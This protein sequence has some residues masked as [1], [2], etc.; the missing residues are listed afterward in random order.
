MII[1]YKCFNKGLI[2]RYG[3]KFIIGQIYHVDKNVSFGNNKHGFHMCVNLEDTL[4]YFDS[5][6]IEIAE[7][8]GFGNYELMEDEYNGFYD[9]YA[10]ENLIIRKILSRDEIINYALNINEFRVQR[11]LQLFVLS[12]E[13]KLLFKEKYKDNK[14]ILDIISYYQ[15][16]NLD[17]YTRKLKK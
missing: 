2:N 5:E 10:V 6:N 17:T 1:G 7:V 12:E 11:F 9:M 14:T 3:K 4:R 13:E 8:I 15:Y 16:H